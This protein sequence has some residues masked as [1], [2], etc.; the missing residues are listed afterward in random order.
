MVQMAAGAPAITS[1]LQ[2]AGMRKGLKK[3]M[4]SPLKDTSQNC[5]HKP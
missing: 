4:P 3:I 2:L 1:A 5:T